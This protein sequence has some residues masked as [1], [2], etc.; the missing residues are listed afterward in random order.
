MYWLK[1]LLTPPLIVLA[2]LL[3]WCEE[4]LWQ[5]LKRL[6]IWVALFPLVRWL[7]S[8]LV[9]L[10]PT[11]MLAI[12]LLPLVTLF[13]LKLLAVYWLTRGYW[14]ASLALIVAA[15]ILG[16]AIVARMYVV[17]HEQLMSIA[18]F[19]FVYDGLSSMRDRVYAALH[20]LPLYQAARAYLRSIKLSASHL[21]NQIRGSNG[22]W[23]R[24]KAIRRWYR[25]KRGAAGDSEQ[26][27]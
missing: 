25:Q 24:W 16:T 9:Q 18:W 4:S 14:F 26:R 27:F 3:I 19:R 12:F 15:K 6:T 1:R 23:L 2:S 11:L 17:C 10:P 20:A 22:I 13:P 21:L 5:V 8:R 7:E